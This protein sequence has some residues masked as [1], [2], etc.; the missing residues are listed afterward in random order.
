M[1]RQNQT[2]PACG[3][4]GSQ[5]SSTFSGFDNSGN[6]Q[7]PAAMQNRLRGSIGSRFRL[8]LVRLILALA[9]IGRAFG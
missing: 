6:S 1:F 5:K 9:Q 7:T 8:V 3:A 2:R 4:A